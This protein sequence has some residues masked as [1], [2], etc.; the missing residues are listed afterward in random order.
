MILFAAIN[1]MK[2]IPYLG[3]DILRAEHLVTIAIL[4]PLGYAGVRLGIFFNKRFTDHWFNLI[5]YSI[6]FIAGVQ[7]ISGKNLIQL[8]GI[9]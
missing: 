3:L 6:L 5:V 1:Q 4:S 2:L 9:V 8:L 7:L